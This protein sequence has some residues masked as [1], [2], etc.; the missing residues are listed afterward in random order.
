M[1]LQA[2]ITDCSLIRKVRVLL[3][4]EDF[5]R[6]PLRALFRRVVWRLRWLLYPD[7]PWLLR[8]HGTMN[9]LHPRT[10][11]GALIYYQGSSEPETA[12]FI[13]R[14]LR[15]GMVFVDC[16]AHLGEYTVLAAT[17]LKSSGH[18]H[19]F[20]PRPDIFELLTRNIELNRCQNVTV[21]PF[22]LW[23]ENGWF[24]F[25]LTPEPSIGALRSAGTIRRGAR[26]IKVQAVT[27]NDYFA[28]RQMASPNLIKIDVEGAE[29][30]LLQGARSL[31]ARPAGE[32]PVLIVEYEPMCLARFGYSF[33]EIFTFLRDLGYSFYEWRRGKLVPIDRRDGGLVRVD[34]SPLSPWKMTKVSDG[35]NLIAA[36]GAPTF[37]A[38][39]D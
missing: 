26:L 20:E 39:L 7:R 18:V 19:A 29:L 9:L 31:L 22:A 32:A 21:R 14:V 11:P 15:P 3:S 16:G 12:N 17:I 33:A 13:E 8:A 30:H 27:L 5:R 4:R 38:R 28:D 23:H 35:P 34:N 10:G 2:R 25:E 37:S 24:E 1:A 36:K 6:H